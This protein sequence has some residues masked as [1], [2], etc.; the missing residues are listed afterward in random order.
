MTRWL[1]AACAAVFLTACA[2]APTLRSQWPASRPA[3]LT[4]TPFFPQ[5]DYQCGPAALATVL[6]ASGV[7]VQ[8]D[9]LAAQVYLPGRK[10]SL[11][12]ELVA[13]A[14]RHQRL[15]YVLKPEI[16]AIFEEVAAGRPVLLLQNLGLSWVPVWHYA[17]VVGV[18]PVAGQV[19]LRS[20][21]EQRRVL[22]YRHFEQSWRLGGRWAM[23]VVPPEQ[24]PATANA[25]DWLAAANAFE[26]LQQPQLARSAYAAAI[27]R[28]PESALAWQAQ[29]NA[30]YGTGDLRAAR[31]AFVEA[32]RLAPDAAGY[33][34]LAQTELDLGC[35]EAAREALQQAS[36]LPATPAVSAALQE[37]TAALL[38]A[39]ANLR[40]S[41]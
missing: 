25:L 26:S 19:I 30:R 40:C 8:P 17:V 11:Q 2:S 10:G 38:R 28:W 37:T 31:A 5:T 6:Q 24:P 27:E 21:R 7:A 34:N 20:G 3:E 22:D 14:R 4:A 18:D 36:A 16:D 41:R 15:P 35:V 9:Q 12:L 29:G 13:A 39:P 23:V 33:N 1:A 32:L